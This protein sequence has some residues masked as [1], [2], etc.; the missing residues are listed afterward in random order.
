MKPKRK[1]IKQ[2]LKRHDRELRALLDK[3]FLATGATLEQGEASIAL[4]A[5]QR[6]VEIRRLCERSIYTIQCRF[7]ATVAD[8]IRAQF[9]LTYATV[10]KPIE[11]HIA[12][13]ESGN[14]SERDFYPNG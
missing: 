7:G 9:E 4:Q 11:A 13:L 6:L 8:Y 14:G 1:E 10:S 12:D 3:P 2:A 5:R